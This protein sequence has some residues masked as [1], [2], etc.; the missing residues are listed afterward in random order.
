MIID[1]MNWTRS[2]TLRRSLLPALLPSL[3]LLLP[4]AKLFRDRG[5][6]C[7]LALAQGQHPTL[8]PPHS[9]AQPSL[10]RFAPP[11]LFLLLPL[12]RGECQSALASRIP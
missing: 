5:T 1:T 4:H 9:H 2:T 6:L 8:E 3:A 12:L 10:V 7:N 11:V